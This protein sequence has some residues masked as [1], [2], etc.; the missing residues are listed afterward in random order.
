MQSTTLVFRGYVEHFPSG[1]Q[2]MDPDIYISEQEAGTGCVRGVNTTSGPPTSF[3][4]KSTLNMD[5][6]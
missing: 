6:R 2:G 1:N 5:I 3:R 4:Q